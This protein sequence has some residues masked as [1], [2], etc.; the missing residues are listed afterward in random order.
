MEKDASSYQKLEDTRNRS[1]QEPLEGMWFSQH[2]DFGPVILLWTFG[3]QNVRE[4]ISVVLV[5]KLM[6]NCIKQYSVWRL[7][8]TKSFIWGLMNCNL[9]DKDLG[10]TERRF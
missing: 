4:Q 9:E 1:P 2:L 5:T 10:E 8:R 3:L 7:Q 6:L